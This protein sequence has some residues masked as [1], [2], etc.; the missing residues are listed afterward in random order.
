M[1]KVLMYL[2][3]LVLL[4]IFLPFKGLV[5][6]RQEKLK[7]AYTED[8]SSITDKEAYL[9]LKDLAWK[10]YS[11][12]N[13]SKAKGYS[14]ELL[15]LNEIVERNWNYGN[16][17]HHSHTV[18]GLVALQA[19]KIEDSKEHLALSAKTTGSPQ[20]HTFG[21]S[22]ILAD[23]LLEKGEKKS[24][25]KFLLNCGKFWEMDKGKISEW[26][27]SIESG[28]ELTLCSEKRT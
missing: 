11:L 17:I 16:A 8:P 19:G 15:R 1:K 18:L 21:P 20:L 2:F 12:K 24:V 7:E 3:G 27:Q 4:I 22:L 5:G 25:K 6:N 10:E 26:V 9:I 28:D 14:L 13:Y 23:K